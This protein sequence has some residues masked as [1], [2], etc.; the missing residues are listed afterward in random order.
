V[1]LLSKTDEI[2]SKLARYIIR[3]KNMIEA[4]TLYSYVGLRSSYSGAARSA[5]EADNRRT[6]TGLTPGLLGSLP[7]LPYV[8]AGQ[9]KI[10]E[11]FSA[12]VPLT[13]LIDGW[14]RFCPGAPVTVMTDLLS[15]SSRKPVKVF[16]Q[17]VEVFER[18]VDLMGRRLSSGW[19]PPTDSVRGFMGG[20]KQVVGIEDRGV[21]VKLNGMIAFPALSLWFSVINLL[22]RGRY[23]HLEA[24]V[25]IPGLTV[26]DI[27]SADAQG[28]E[29][30][31]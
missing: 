20:N 6:F 30:R 13:I 5:K 15:K 25:S 7:G 2:T 10:K 26:L 3:G 16:D 8:L 11:R 23:E 12:R 29:V 21:T 18:S 28:R 1:I 9:I 27:V 4:P 31:G 22:P 19:R 14:Q 24:R 17:L